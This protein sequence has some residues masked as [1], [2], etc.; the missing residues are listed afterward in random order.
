MA[1]D[2]TTAQSLAQ[3]VKAKELLEQDRR[4]FEDCTS[5]RIIGKFTASS[6]TPAYLTTRVPRL[7]LTQ[8]V[9]LCIGGTAFIGLG[10]YT[11]WEGMKHLEA[12]R[13][14]ILKSKSLVSMGGRKAGIAGISIGLA[15]MGIYRLFG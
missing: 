5:C 4:Q 10:G 2:K 3:P 12:N 9:P 8:S 6:A 11:Y 15:W 13:A 14:M 1:G 7:L